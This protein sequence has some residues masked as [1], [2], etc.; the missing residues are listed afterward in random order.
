M[1]SQ[2]RGYVR[3]K[4]IG[5]AGSA[6]VASPQVRTGTAPG[7]AASPA[8][9]AARSM[10]PRFGRHAPAQCAAV[11][12]A[13]E[14]KVICHVVGS[15]VKLNMQVRCSHRIPVW[16]GGLAPRLGGGRGGAPSPAGRRRVAGPAARIFLGRPAGVPPHQ[17]WP[18]EA[19]PRRQRP[20]PAAFACTPRCDIRMAIESI[21]RRQYPTILRFRAGR[22]GRLSLAGPAH[23]PYAGG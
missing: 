13:A 16:S 15:L 8:G 21:R 7:A 11:A 18:I 5:A 9:H 19:Y 3:S 22:R 20:D 14:D 12:V 1:R 17:P 23:R 6:G 10:R 2:H 4:L